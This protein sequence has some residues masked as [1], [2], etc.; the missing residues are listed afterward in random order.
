MGIIK[1][2]KLF[3]KKGEKIF[4]IYTILVEQEKFFI[5]EY[6]GKSKK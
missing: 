5:G 6:C 2:L 3:K 4:F 1:K